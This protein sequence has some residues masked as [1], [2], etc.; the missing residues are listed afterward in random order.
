M[1]SLTDSYDAA[2]FG[3]PVERGR[4]PA[5]LV[6]D[7]T[8]GFTEAAFPT[9][10]D[11]TAPVTRTAALAEAARTAALPVVFTV[12]KYRSPFEG[13]TWRQKAPG[14][15]ALRH[16]SAAVELDPRLGRRPD[17]IIVVKHG[18]S[19]FFG[20]G[21]APLLIGLGVDTV[22]LCG[23]TTSGCVRASAVDA[24]QY[25][26]PTLVPRDCVAD[27]A[28]APHEAS[29]FDLQAKYA[30]VITAD[31]AARYLATCSAQAHSP[32]HP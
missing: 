3:A 5:L 14:M 23:A 8:R 13:R 15:S 24:V 19:A 10:A 21:L 31:D 4:R 16:G 17:D 12:I 11:M 28:C 27:R 29:L 7:F 20:T 32:V 30:D 6:V 22:V 26:F 9:G 25:G 1:T 18:P 2:G